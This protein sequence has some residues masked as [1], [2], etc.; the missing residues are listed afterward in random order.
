MLLASLVSTFLTSTV[1]FMPTLRRFLIYPSIRIKCLPLSVSFAGQLRTVVFLSGE[2]NSKASP[3]VM[4]SHSI[5][6]GSTRAIFLPTS[7]CSA[8]ATFSVSNFDSFY[9]CFHECSC[10]YC[11]H[12]YWETYFIF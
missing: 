10:P 8:S 11:Y 3:L 6:S 4:L 9:L 12:Q 1:S 5:I 7:L 2:I